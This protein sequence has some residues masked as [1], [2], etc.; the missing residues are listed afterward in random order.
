M[1]QAV[2]DHD[3]GTGPVAS[4]AALHDATFVT[5]LIHAVIHPEGMAIYYPDF[6][7]HRGQPGVYIQDLYAVPTARRTGLARALLSAV[8]HHQT[9][10]ARYMTLG[11]SASN[12]AANRFYAKAGFTPRGYQMMILDGLNLES[13]T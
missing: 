7:T 10:G 8:M 6:S 11:V 1:L 13:L 5:R 3:G 4:E 9:W 2:S 12:I